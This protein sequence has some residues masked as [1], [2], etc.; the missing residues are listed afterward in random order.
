MVGPFLSVSCRLQC[1]F[2]DLMLTLAK[3]HAVY[4][5]RPNEIGCVKVLWLM[6]LAAFSSKRESNI[7]YLQGDNCVFRHEPS[8]L[9]CE[10]MCTAWQQGKCLDKRCKLRH[11]ELRVCHKSIMVLY[12]SQCIIWLR[13]IV[14]AK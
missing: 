6:T 12:A 4:H 5:N 1:L 3:H 9:G 7:T 11:M 13:K 8:A 14:L 10:T 2:Y